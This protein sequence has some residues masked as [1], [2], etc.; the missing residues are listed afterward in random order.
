[1]LLGTAILS[2]SASAIDPCGADLD[3]GGRVDTDDLLTLLEQWELDTWCAAAD[4]NR[5]RVVGVDDLLMLVEQWGSCESDWATHFVVD[6]GIRV[7][8]AA[9]P[10]AGVSPDGLVYLYYRDKTSSPGQRMV[11]VSQDGLTFPDGVPE[12]THEHDSRATLLPDGTWRM[13]LWNPD[14]E[15]MRSSSSVDGVRYIMDEGVRYS[16]QP[17]D[18]GTMGIYRAFSD[19]EGRV[20]LLYIG[21]MW[22]LNNVRRAVS[23]DG[24]W[25]FTFDHG[26]VLGDAGDGGTNNSWVDQFPTRLPGCRIRLFVMRDGRIGS[27]LSNGDQS[28]FTMEAEMILE[29]E[30]VAGLA[31][32]S[33][34]DPAVVQ[35][36][37]GRWRMYLCAFVD[38]DPQ[39]PGGDDYEC[40]IS[41]TAAP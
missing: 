26:D 19:A 4:V 23:Y 11:S 9:E 22:G 39:G 2:G 40:L 18:E 5:D 21:A 17:E 10:A 25:T 32:R 1:M 29:P 7:M 35:L 8:S 13:Y 37:D 3:G 24:G 31:V 34:H 20:V 27:F 30:D 36:P 14:D 15:V 33:L 28:V 38:N 41:A 16:L 12:T 6:E